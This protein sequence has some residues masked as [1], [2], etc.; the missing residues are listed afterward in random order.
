LRVDDVSGIAAPTG[1]ATGGELMGLYSAQQLRAKR[2]RPELP[3]W[4]E[5]APMGSP[6]ERWQCIAVLRHFPGK[7]LV[8]Q[9]QRDGSTVLFKLFFEG[10]DYHRELRGY[11]YLEAAAITTPEIQRHGILAEGGSFIVY[12]FIAGQSLEQHNAA[13]PLTPESSI[14]LSTVDTLAVMHRHGLRQTDIHLGNFL[15]YRDAIYVVDTAAIRRSKA[16]LKERSAV[17]NFADL[18]GQFKPGQMDMLEPLIASYN[19]G[20]SGITL[21]PGAV[22]VAVAN[23]R[24]S[25]WRHYRGKLT[26]TC[27]EF[28]CQRSQ[29]RFGVWRRDLESPA[30]Q[31][32]LHDLDRTIEQG[33]YLKQGNTATVARAQ[34]DGQARVIK[35]YNIKGWRHFLSRCWRPTRGWRSWHNA[36]YLLFNG[37]TTPQPI[38]LVEERLGPLRGRAFYLCDYVAGDSLKSALQA[39]APGQRQ[40]LVDEFAA[41]VD[42]YYRAGI[43]HGDMKADNFIVTPAGITV[44]D[45]DPMQYHR[46]KTTLESA[47][48]RDMR[49]FLQNFTGPQGQAITQQLLGQIPE[50]LRP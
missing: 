18:V 19:Q 14:L 29:R 5:F 30:L 11:G 20:K 27:S 36:H 34:I 33:S 38:A 31:R 12:Q 42:H 24:A 4:L 7:R 23:K 40:Q 1:A 26:R 13:N 17:A 46:D 45:L 28:N 10:R 15:S 9:L 2:F 8:L 39:A 49:R 48:K 16:P 6:T 41:I 32:V 35:R 25:R 22:R 50:A 43:S 3:F 47:L 37:L 21:D 44:I